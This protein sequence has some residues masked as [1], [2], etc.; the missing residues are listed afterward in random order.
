MLFSYQLF[1]SYFHLL[2]CCLYWKLRGDIP[3]ADFLTKRER[4]SII[5][6][7][8][9]IYLEKKEK[10]INKICNINI[11]ISIYIIYIYNI[12]MYIYVYI[13]ISDCGRLVT[14][15]SDFLLRLSQNKFIFISFANLQV[16]VEWEHIFSSDTCFLLIHPTVLL[17]IQY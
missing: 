17:N 15:N 14:S 10:G 13:Y 5:T 11:N 6:H 7:N 8:A 16:C 3:I 2:Q 4:G 12:Y 9:I 1:P